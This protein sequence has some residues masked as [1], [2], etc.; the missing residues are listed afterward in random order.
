MQQTLTSY[1]VIA[2]KKMEF[3]LFLGQEKQFKD[4]WKVVTETLL[5]GIRDNSKYAF[6]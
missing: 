5:L 3:S 4:L 1:K 6:I 2:G